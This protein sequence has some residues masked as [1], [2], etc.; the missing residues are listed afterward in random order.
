MDP[1]IPVLSIMD[2]GMIR[3]VEASESAIRVGL[4]PTYSAC[5]AM[6]TICDS[7]R[8][9]LRAAHFQDVEIVQVLDPPWTTSDMTAAGRVKLEIY[10][11]A[12]PAEASK[13]HLFGAPRSCP[14]CRSSDTECISEFGSTPCK[15]LYRCRNC[16]EPFD[17]FKCL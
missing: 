6:R 15:A 1:E 8:E 17:Y 2:L 13:A 9:S 14:R 10:G 11:I 3:F 4:T 12:P 7:L 16:R 5:P